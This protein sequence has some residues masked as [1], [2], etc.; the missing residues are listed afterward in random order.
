MTEPKMTVHEMTADEGAELSTKL[1]NQI[2]PLLHGHPPEVQGA[3]LADLTATWLAGHPPFLRE[4]LLAMQ[5]Q[6]ITELTVVADEE[7]FGAAGHPQQ[8]QPGFDYFECPECG[9]DSVL[10]ASFDGSDS[11]PLCAGDS[12]HDV[13]MHRRT[14]QTT[15]RPEGKDARKEAAAAPPD[16]Q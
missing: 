3:V 8:E 12:G 4:Q 14:A 15:D 13:A 10:P 9:F 1:Y 7:L 5:H 16:V 2:G 6:M 11:C